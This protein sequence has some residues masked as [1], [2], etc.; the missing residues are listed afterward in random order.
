MAWFF[1]LEANCKVEL[2]QTKN[3]LEVGFK[4]SLEHL[5]VANISIVEP[6]FNHLSGIAARH[7]DNV[8]NS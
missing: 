7:K 4:D 5:E 8:S 6:R 3:G 1:L 2:R